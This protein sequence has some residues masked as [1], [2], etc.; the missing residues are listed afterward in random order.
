MGNGK[1]RW[2]QAVQKIS[3]QHQQETALAS[4]GEDRL[5]RLTCPTVCITAHDA[6]NKVT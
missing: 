6:D 2:T 3:I 1:R 5:Q 4:I